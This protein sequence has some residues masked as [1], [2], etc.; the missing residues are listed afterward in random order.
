[1]ITQL[2][3]DHMIV[4]HSI[5]CW[6][7]IQIPSHTI[8]QLLYVL[9][10]TAHTFSR[11]LPLGHWTFFIEIFKEPKV[12][13]V[14]IPLGYPGASG[15]LVLKYEILAPLP[16]SGK[17]SVAL[18]ILQSSPEVQTESGLHLNLDCA[19]LLFLCRPDFPTLRALRTLLQ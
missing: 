6:N 9:L 7:A 11:G 18:F 2:I 15:L 8:P 19:W 5:G 16:Q 10:L 3:N 13:G 4:C 12:L 1:M 17:N 14:Y